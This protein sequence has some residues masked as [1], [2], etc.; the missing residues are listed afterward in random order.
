[1]KRI[2]EMSG[3]FPGHGMLD[4]TPIVLQY[5]LDA[6]NAILRNPE[7]YDSISLFET[8]DGK[9]ITSYAKYIQQGTSMKY[10]MN[11]IYMSKKDS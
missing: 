6:C 10:T 7:N 3:V 1:M 5:N 11:S 2:H 9:T 4:Q 8:P